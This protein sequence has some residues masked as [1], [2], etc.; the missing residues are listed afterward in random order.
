MI[1]YPENDSE[2]EEHAITEVSGDAP[3][4][5]AI[6]NAG[7]WLFCGKDCAEKP[8]VGSVARQYGRGIGSPVRGLFI[9]GV[10]LWYRTPAQED[11][12]REIQ[13]YGADASDWLK[14]WDD[15]QSVWTIE[16]G[17]L[18]PGYEQCIHMTAAECVRF[19]LAGKYEA[20]LWEDRDIWKKVRD[21]LEAASFENAT[22]KALG[23]S[24]AQW[25]AAVNIAVQIYRRGPRA[26]MT[27]AALKDRH[28]QVS[29]NFPQAA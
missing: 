6:S 27:D 18:G 14:R 26:V 24:G 16:M 29:K 23:L 8:K 10:K 5:Y 22:I 15:G 21:D 20:S 2:Y 11:E 4:E 1:D 12:H 13:S 9:N 7:W 19:F 28:I 25:G 3:G 17:G